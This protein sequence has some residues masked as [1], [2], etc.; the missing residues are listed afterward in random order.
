MRGI[1]RGGR[2]GFIGAFRGYYYDAAADMN[3]V[4]GMAIEPAQHIGPDDLVRS[5]RGGATIGQ[6]DDAIHE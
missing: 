6:V 4:D 2:D 5:P 3:D 1:C